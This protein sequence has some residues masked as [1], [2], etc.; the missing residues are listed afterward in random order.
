MYLIFRHELHNQLIL[1]FPIETNNCIVNECRDKDYISFED[2][3]KILRDELK[4]PEERALYFVKKFDKNN[5]GKLSA[6]EFNL[7]KKNVEET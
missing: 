6:S 3:M 7:F 2:A 4:Y 1:K 5:D